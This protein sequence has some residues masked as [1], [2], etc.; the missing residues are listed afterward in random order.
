MLVACKLSA[1]YSNFA[2]FNINAL[3][4]IK[5]NG[6]ATNGAIDFA[7]PYLVKHIEAGKQSSKIVFMNGWKYFL[8]QWRLRVFGV[9]NLL[10]L[11]VILGTTKIIESLFYLSLFCTILS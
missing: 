10:I 3:E 1:A 7:I 11:S 8:L 4:V 2:G 9:W 6:I 5:H